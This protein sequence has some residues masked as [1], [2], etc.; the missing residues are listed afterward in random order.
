M[1]DNSNPVNAQH[2]SDESIEALRH[3]IFTGDH[4]TAKAILIDRNRDKTWFAVPS[5]E[6]T[7]DEVKAFARK[8]T[9]AS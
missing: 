6:T 8:L 4:V 2:I 5:Q 1:S 3:W 9:E 7:S